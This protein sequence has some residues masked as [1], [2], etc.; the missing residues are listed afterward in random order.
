MPG[1]AS[2]ISWQQLKAEAPPIA[3]LAR[4]RFEVTRIALLGT[5]RRNGSPRV[6]PVE[7]YLSDGQLLFGAMSRS[8]KTRDLLHDPRCVLHSAITGPDAGEPEVKLYGRVIEASAELRDGCSAGWWQSRP[9]AAVVFAFRVEQATTIDWNLKE[10]QMV[11]RRWSA[12]K[13][14]TESI[15][16]YP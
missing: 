9:D 10:S 3:Q 7:P 4:Q 8:L 2:L 14:L 15:R 16:S 6:S 5:L 11:V 1:Q 12:D 13:G